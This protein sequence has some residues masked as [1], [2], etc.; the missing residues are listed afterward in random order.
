MVRTPSTSCVPAR[1][2][3]EWRQPPRKSWFWGGGGQLV[4]GCLP[5]L[6][7]QADITIL[8]PPPSPRLF[9]PCPK[10]FFPLT[11]PRPPLS[12]ALTFLPALPHRQQQPNHFPNPT[13]LSQDEELNF[14]RTSAYIL[15]QARSEHPRLYP[16]RRAIVLSPPGANRKPAAQSQRNR[17]KESQQ[18]PASARKQPQK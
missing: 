6:S 9:P 10:F 17:R 1:R 18:Q 16:L 5:I 2:C 7:L 3:R 8:S 12:S 11:P 14:A 4:P 13:Q 15:R